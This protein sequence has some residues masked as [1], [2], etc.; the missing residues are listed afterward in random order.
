MRG[1]IFPCEV[2]TVVTSLTLE[3][4]SSLLSA[5]QSDDLLSLERSFEFVVLML[6]GS[7]HEMSRVVLAAVRG[8]FLQ[9]SLRGVYSNLRLM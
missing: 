5:C 9:S 7:R 6:L 3:P 2:Y 8:H 4:A 1:I